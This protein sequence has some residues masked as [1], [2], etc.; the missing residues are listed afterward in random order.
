LGKKKCV[1]RQCRTPIPQIASG[2]CEADHYNYGTGGCARLIKIFVK[3]PYDI[4]EEMDLSDISLSRAVLS[5]PPLK[6]NQF[7]LCK[8]PSLL[9]SCQRSRRPC[10]SRGVLETQHTQGP[11][12]QQL[13][14][15][16]E[17]R[18]VYHEHRDE[19]SLP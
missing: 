5:T 4:A 7:P 12:N 11:H 17:M 3:R 8:L 19:D 18:T 16:G 10:S 14:R 13:T 1:R 6:K 9:L 2:T 15:D